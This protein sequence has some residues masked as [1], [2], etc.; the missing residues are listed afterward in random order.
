MPLDAWIAR[1][2]TALLG[3]EGAERWEGRLP[4]LFK[5]LAAARPLSIQAHPSLA[6]ARAGYARENGAG[7]APDAPNRCYRDPNHKPELICAL[8][9]FTALDRFR[10]PAEILRGFEALGVEG[11]ALA[12]LHEGGR[13]GLARGF[14]ALMTPGAERDRLLEAAVRAARSADAS[15]EH[16]WVAR[17]AEAWPGDVGALAPLLLNLVRLEPGEALYLPA[18]ELHSYLEGVGVELMANSDNVLRGGLT[19]KHV[20]VPELLATLSFESGPAERLRPRPAAAGEQRYAAPVEEFALS[21][22]RAPYAAPA[23]RGLEILLC[24]EGEGRLVTAR[25]A[26]DVARGAIWLVP[27][28]APPYRLEGAATLYRAAVGRWD[29]GSKGPSP[30]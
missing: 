30:G 28:A 3:A 9:P 27:A 13:D 2:P 14:E 24:T 18:G 22:L 7:L 1:D 12:P 10:R 5:V 25:Q 19:E 21:V 15:P 16:A 23:R 26:L 11:E 8:T 17:L 20:D 29:P 4:F 6:Q